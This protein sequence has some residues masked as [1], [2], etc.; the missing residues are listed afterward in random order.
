[1]TFGYDDIDKIED[2][3]A[4]TYEEYTHMIG[5]LDFSNYCITHIVKK[6]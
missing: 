1:M 3:E 2:I 4:Y 5:Q 6:V